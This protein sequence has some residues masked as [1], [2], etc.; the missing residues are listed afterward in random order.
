MRTPKIKGLTSLASNLGKAVHTHKQLTPNIMTLKNILLFTAAFAATAASHSE[1][2]PSERKAASTKITINAPEELRTPLASCLYKEMRELPFVNLVN[3]GEAWWIDFSAAKAGPSSWAISHV[4]YKIE[5]IQLRIK[6]L[7]SMAERP[8]DPIF[9]ETLKKLMPERALSSKG[10]FI[11][12]VKSVDVKKYC[13]SISA[14]YH[15]NFI[16]PYIR[17]GQENRN[18]Q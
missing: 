6:I 8:S 13:Q 12:I 4:V 2:T 14:G 17:I 16:D 3:E 1:T 7:E 9:I 5:P 18:N 15:V 11:S 10:H